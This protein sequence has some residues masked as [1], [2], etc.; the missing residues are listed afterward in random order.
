MKSTHVETHLS[1][2]AF[3]A[4][5]SMLVPAPVRAGGGVLDSTFGTDGTVL[6]DF[7]GTDD[8]ALAVAIQPNGKMI[9]AGRS[10]IY[11]V[12][13]AALVRY[14]GDGSLDPAFGAD[15][16]VTAALDPGGDGVSAIALQPD[17]KIV[18]AG[19]VVH[20]N[21]PVAIVAARFNADGSLDPSFGSGGIVITTFGDPTAEGNDVVLQADGKIVVAGVS[22]AGPYS[23]LNDFALVRYNADGSLDQGFGNG[24]KIKTHFPG[25]FN[26]GS[27]ATS[28]V[29]QAD[30]KLVVAG[31]YKNEGTHRQVALARYETNG[32]LDGAFGTAGKVTTT[33]GLGDA[34]GYAM[35]LQPDQ[36][37]VVAGYSYSNQG[38]DF[39][40][41]RYRPDGSLD[42]QFGEGGLVQTDLGGG[43]TDISYAVAVQR[44][45][46]VAAGRTGP[47]PETNTGLARYTSTGQLD[48][49]FGTGGTVTTDIGGPDQGYALALSRGGKI[50]VAGISLAS[51][52]TFDFA[53]A[54]YLGH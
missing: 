34:A 30:G 44:G 28:V 49:T 37:I 48:P 42:P 25:V 38:K 22:G 39:T 26:T 15:G 29:Q 9:V 43:T 41:A 17:G 21:W 14:N 6:T 3:I 7:S 47:Y 46:L 5:V 53:V 8:Y 24:G 12:F 32:S 50:V 16:T 4:V 20:D 19:S 45:M 52:S 18:A 54:R 40:L 27:A 23:E 10:G 1:V 36:R 31:E 11:P 35:T 51:G 13:H 33:V 2:A